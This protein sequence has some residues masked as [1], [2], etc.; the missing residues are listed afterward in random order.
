MKINKYIVI[1]VIAA[2]SFLTACNDFLDTNSLS[3]FD[4]KYVFSNSD[5]AKKAVLGVYALFAQ[6]S[7]TSRMS[8]T[9]M[10]NTDVEVS[11][12]GA[13]PD[14]SRR[15][16][17]SLQA[18]LLSSFGDVKTAWDHNYLAIDR[19]NQCIEGI[20]SSKASGTKDMKMLLAES[21]C[22]RA[23]RYFMLCNFWGDVPYFRQAA[24]AGMQLDVPKTDKNIIYS[25]LIQDL[26]NSE[27]DMY[28]SDEFSD[29][30]ER[31]NRDFALG[32]ICRLSL[33]RAGYGMTQNGTMKRADDYLNVQ[34]NDSLA[35]KYT[36]NGVEKTARTSAEYYQLAKDYAQKLI[37]MRDRE[38]KDYA[39]IFVNECKWIKTVNE[40]VLYEVAFGSTNGGGDVGWCIGVP[41]SASSYGT[42]TI[43]VGYNPAYFF[44]FD[45]KD[46]RRDVCIS[47]VSYSSD[48]EQNTLGITSL[49]VGKWNRLL[50]KTAPGATSSKGTGI[51]WPVMRYSD[52]LLMLAEA[53]NELNGPTDLAKS[54][55]K[56][57]RN[58]AF[59]T[60]NRATKVEN[61]VDSVAGSKAAFFNA[62]VNERAWEFGGECLRKFDLVRWNNYG[63][64]IIET[65]TLLSNIGKATNGLELDNPDVAKYAGYAKKIYY[66]KVD[67][68][69]TFLNDYTEP[70]TDQVNAWVVTYGSVTSFSWGTSLYKKIT[71]TDGTVTWAVADYTNYCWR[72]YLDPAGVGAVPYLMPISSQTVS[73]SSYLKND[74][75]GLVSTNN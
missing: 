33:F 61:Y 70:T 29:G 35:V 67:G 50:L 26:V 7:Y 17:W 44:S 63:Q 10:Q 24:K 4:T 23:Y 43:Q 14:G 55:L 1:I 27:S 22:L 34:T 71:A 36:I 13:A 66:V 53:E 60:N 74:G 3:N 37:S 6:D 11:A 42:T 25:G 39:T 75:Y 48:V 19:A 52:V 73:A 56:K 31:M 45:V 64:K 46:K 30:I 68:K 65:K 47:R 62:I 38:L 49:A 54:L 72:G 5:D 59:D 69:I 18:G 41:V 15:D 2:S 8:N 58:R 40:D 21:Y 16:I 9:W 32:M 51:N 20:Q 12:P 28:F 57:V